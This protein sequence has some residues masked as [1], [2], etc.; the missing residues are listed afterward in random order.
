MVDW[1][2]LVDWKGLGSG[3]PRLVWKGHFFGEPSDSEDLSDVTL[4]SE[5]TDDPVYPDEAYQKGPEF[6]TWSQLGTK[7]YFSLTNFPI[8]LT[9][10]KFLT[11][12]PIKMERPSRSSNGNFLLGALPNCPPDSVRAQFD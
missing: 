1:Y 4:E 12:F 6:G 5:D 9:T 10:P 8:W 11:T 2:W 7:S 3:D